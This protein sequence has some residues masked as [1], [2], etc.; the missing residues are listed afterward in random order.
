MTMEALHE[1]GCGTDAPV[2]RHRAVDVRDEPPAPPFELDGVTAAS[3]G[4]RLVSRRAFA[5]GDAVWPL[6]GRIVDRSERTIQVGPTTHVE[7]ESGLV[8]LRHS[9]APNLVIDTD[10]LLM[11]FALR[12]V[13]AGEELTC[14]YPSTEWDMARPFVC[15]CGAPQC[16]RFVAGARYLSADV[17]GRYFVNAHVR[18]LLTAAVGRPWRP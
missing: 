9:C 1:R 10:A 11:V 13:A 7:D 17:L 3:P 12:D 15:G 16:L 6:S 2:H 14:F 8:L 4:R 5:R 18:R